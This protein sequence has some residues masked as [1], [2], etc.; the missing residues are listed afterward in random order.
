MSASSFSPDDL[1]SAI[2]NLRAF[3]RSLSGSRD[4][5]D[6]LVQETLLK[7]WSK[8][9]QFEAGT[10]LHAWLFTILRNI[11]YSGYR[12]TAHEIEDSDGSYANRLISAPSQ[13][14]RLDLE[15]LRKAL[16]KLSGDQR[17]AVLLVGADGLRYEDAAKVCGCTLGTLKSRV[18]RGRTNLAKH[19]GLDDTSSIGFEATVMAVLPSTEPAVGAYA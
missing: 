5:A 18:H 7:A 13:Y 16:T 6:D 14:G 1:V 9:E 8:M 15:D 2:S 11:H 10:C 17:D 3:A 19:L 4:H 12:R